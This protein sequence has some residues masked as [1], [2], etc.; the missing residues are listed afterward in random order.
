MIKQLNNAKSHRPLSKPEWPENPKEVPTLFSR[1]KPLRKMKVLVDAELLASSNRSS[2][3]DKTTVLLAL[4]DSDLIEFY[5][6]NDGL[7]PTGVLPLEFPK[8]PPPFAVYPGWAV[9]YPR[10]EQQGYWP[11][12]Y[13]AKPKESYSMAGVIGN[14]TDVARNDDSQSV[15]VELDAEQ[16]AN[17]REMDELA[18]QVA[19]QALQA[20]VYITD[21]P[22][23]HSGS[24]LVLE[25]GVTVCTLEEALTLV[26]L[27][28][29][30]QGEFVLP[31][32]TKAVRFSFNRGLYF[33]VGARELLP[34]AWRWFSACVQHSSGSGDEKLLLLG[35]SLLSRVTKALQA[36]DE[37]HRSLSVPPNNDMSD[38][39]LGSLDNVFVL[40][41]GA[42]DV[43]ARVA[44]YVLNLPA[45]T[46]Y[47]AAWQ[48]A[49]WRGQFT[50]TAP[51][52]SAIGDTGTSGE[53]TLTILRLLRNSVHG[54][55]LQ[56]TRLLKDGKE[57]VLIGLP[58]D[59]EIA[60]L[61]AMDA[62]GG[63]NSWGFRSIRPGRSHIEPAVL[64][65][66]LF[67]GVV[68][69][70]NDLMR[71]TPVEVLSSVTI[72]AGHSKPP[73]EDSTKGSFDTFSEWNR[74]AIRWQLG[75]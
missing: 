30:A 15:Y 25:P 10:D 64:V 75:F 65:D 37:V 49:N 32:D 34:E 53:R 21:R 20:D 31:T 6:Y 2:K 48:K 62:M 59:D 4:L 74:L 41:M 56:G 46:E 43:S 70:L 35:G 68:N 71:E 33:W 3:I 55:A 8:F 51:R 22:Y 9:A 28:L 29:R 14:A 73:V 50:T 58:V 66:R 36:R 40:L 57:E 27:Y 42:V 7:P 16:R 61:A 24:R 67:E 60:I 54:A 5:R 13:S 11:V 1:R 18:L 52:L 44:H 26:A 19:S 23:L 38:D 69:L 12:T 45:R 72:T 17:K 39:A 47:S 63:R